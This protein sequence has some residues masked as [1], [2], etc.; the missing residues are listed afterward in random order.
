[1]T[2]EVS[3]VIHRFGATAA[4]EG[5]SLTLREGE[6]AALLGPSGSGKTTLLRILAGL[7]DTD[8]GTIRIAGQ[9]VTGIPAR[10]RGIGMVFQSYALFRHMT[11]FENV[12]FGLRVRPRR[13]PESEIATRVRRLLDM[14]QVPELERRYPAQISGGQR[15]R[16]AL[17]R[18]LAIEPRLL[19]LDEPFSALDALVRKEVRRWLRG[20]H[21][22]LG[23]TT[24]LVTHDQ[25]EAM[26]LADR[27]AVME[28]GR[29][30]QFDT[31]AALLAEPASPFVAAFVGEATRLD[32]SVRDGVV[33]FEAPSLAPLRAALPDGPALAF[34]QAHDIV[35]EAGPGEAR[36]RVV[37]QTADGRRLLVVQAGDVML[38]ATGSAGAAMTPGDACRLTL[39]GGHLFAADG[40][41]VLIAS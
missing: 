20:L 36:V 23:I 12:A 6:F 32:C 22:R 25:Q 28:R 8:S 27:I 21:D 3:D 18:A 13:P 39:R 16:V 5:V 10:E 2:V 4:L 30:A 1:M 34:V 11:V 31:A 9:D 24:V 14:M 33:H 17:A 41:R 38:D 26:E 7:E 37:R 19:L 40:N 15:Q 29:I 35:A